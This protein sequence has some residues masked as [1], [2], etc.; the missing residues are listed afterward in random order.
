[1]E[2]YNYQ[3]DAVNSTDT[4]KK[5]IL[6]LPTGT[7]KT[8]IQSA[9][10][11]KDIQN[12]PNQFRMY[13]VNA[14][15]ILLTFQ[16]LT[17]VFKHL[18]HLGDIRYHFVHS[19]NNFDE[20]DLDVFLKEF[21]LEN[22]TNIP[23]SPKDNGTSIESITDVIKTSQKLNV[24]L[25]LFSTYNSAPR[26]VTATQQTNSKISIVFNDES[27]YLVQPT[28]HDIIDLLK[29]ERQYFFT[30]TLRHKPSDEGR[31]M[32]NIEK[33]GRV[34]KELKPI[35]AIEMGKMVRPR[36]VWLETDGV[37][38]DEDLEKSF[39][40]VLLSLYKQHK[41]HF[42]E[43]HPTLNPKILVST[44]GI[45]QIKPFLESNE[46]Q[47]LRNMDVDIFATH[48]KL[49]KD[50]N[51]N[52]E[53][54]NRSKFL[55]TLKEYGK[56]PDKKLIVLHYDILTEGL[57][58]PGFT[59]CIPF[60]N[61]QKSDFVQT[62]GRCS[63][64]DDRDRKKFK[65]FN[66][67]TPIPNVPS[68]WFVDTEWNKPFAYVIFPHI[69]LTNKDDVASMVEIVEEL[70]TW[71]YELSQMINEKSDPR[72][73]DNEPEEGDDNPS[74]KGRTIRQIFSIVEDRRIASLSPTDMYQENLEQ[75]NENYNF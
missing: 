50:C 9:I 60:R 38:T 29:T 6:V 18:I 1:M 74:T 21:N 51:I 3:V 54:V 58:V 31:G 34:L 10:I 28:F 19:G 13:V 57:D 24:P 35:D 23:Y 40:I 70:R 7:G 11:E 65:N 17:E 41:Q 72:G 59:S 39:N 69:T 49:P 2:L 47:E 27:H 46:Y 52:G 8:R 37:K 61:L 22:N 15:R 68:N 33:Y 56:N 32:N 43:N 53:A 12:H 36:M 62:F 14:P 26:I 75:Y 67:P 71:D 63:R 25:I 4:N 66:F 5:G 42:E 73:N 16:L 30:A 44:N 48:T 64:L 45:G 55:T 20:S